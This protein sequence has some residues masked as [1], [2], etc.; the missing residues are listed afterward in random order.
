[1][2][3]TALAQGVRIS[4]RGGHAFAINYAPEPRP[5]PVAEGTD[6]VLGS[7]ILPPAGVAIWKAEP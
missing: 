2:A 7:A 3:V 6:L 4:Q 5:V 1:L